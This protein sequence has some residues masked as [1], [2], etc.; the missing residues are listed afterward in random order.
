MIFLGHGN[1]SSG[2]AQLVKVTGE[3]TE[4]LPLCSVATR[5]Q[6][7]SYLSGGFVPVT[8]SLERPSLCSLI[9]LCETGM[10]TFYPVS[11]GFLFTF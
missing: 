4:N 3:F 8:P 1:H 11:S 6:G 5:Q 9:L 2:P 7:D 10:T